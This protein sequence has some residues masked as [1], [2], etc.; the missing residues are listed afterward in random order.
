MVN[1]TI[2]DT[3]EQAAQ[4]STTWSLHLVSFAVEILEL[5][6]EEALALP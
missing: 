1:Y 6:G 5:F 2:E 4:Q 3:V